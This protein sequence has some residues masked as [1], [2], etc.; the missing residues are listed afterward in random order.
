[1]IASGKAK[2]SE[3]S[4]VLLLFSGGMDSSAAAILLT[5]RFAKIRLLT[6]TPPYEFGCRRLTAARVRRLRRLLPEVEFT[7]H[8]AGNY[9]LLCLLKPFQAV[10]EARSTLLFCTVCKLSMH[11]KAIE[12]CRREGVKYAA[13]GIGVREQQNFPD[14][15]PDLEFRVNRLYAEAGITRLSPVKDRSKKEVKELLAG[16]GLYPRLI[17]PRCPVKQIQELFWFF[18]GFPADEK[19]LDWY[20][21]RLPLMKRIVL[22]STNKA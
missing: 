20:D 19:I 9:H 12:V 1:M 22:K 15:L 4:G 16:Y 17:F 3:K 8:F 6:C 11:L 10:K 7:Q 14:Q 18:F 5:K 13:S 2:P 21:S